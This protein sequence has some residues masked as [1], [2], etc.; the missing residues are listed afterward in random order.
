[1]H[2]YSITNKEVYQTVQIQ[3]EHIDKNEIQQNSSPFTVQ[4]EEYVGEETL[5]VQHEELIEE[6]LPNI[7]IEIIQD[8]PGISNKKICNFCGISVSKSSWLQHYYRVHCSNARFH[9]DFC[10]KEFRVKRDLADHMKIHMNI[11]YRPK[12]PCFHCSAQFL[13]R[14]SLKTHNKTFHSDIVEQHPCDLCGKVFISRLKLQQHILVVHRKGSHPCPHCGKDF[15]VKYNLTK[16]IRKDHGEKIPCKLCQK[17]VPPGRYMKIHLETHDPPKFE[18]T[19]EG[20]IKKFH[21]EKSLNYH[22]ETQHEQSKSFECQ[23]CL[24]LFNSKKNLSRHMSRQHNSVKIPCSIEGC[25]HM[26][27]RKDYL[28]SH[29]KNHKGIDEETR[30]ML[31]E[32]V[33]KMKEIPW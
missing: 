9:C 25:D 30:S 18:C 22:I 5:T 10:G 24:S 27:S 17:L 8:D 31:L 14:S 16:H 2:L 4:Y 20:C 29:Y 3:E 6:D 32:K 19:Y 23:T 33:K 15:S 21:S 11:K 13:S 26:A 7:S 1:M 12:F 28:A